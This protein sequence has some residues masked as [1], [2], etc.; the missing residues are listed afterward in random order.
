MAPDDVARPITVMQLL[1]ALESGGVERSTIE[2]AQA[3]AGAG[4]RALVVSAGGRLVAD[5]EAVGGHHLELEIGRKSLFTLRHVFTLRRL[6]EQYRPDIVHARSRL[7]A[8]IGWLA[9]RGLRGPRPAFVTTVHGLNSVSGYSAILTRGERVICVS[10][11]VRSHVLAHYP[12]VDPARLRVIER[13]VDAEDFP[14]GH[15]ADAAWRAAF[16]AAHPALSE[17]S[18]FVLPGRGTRLKGHEQAIDFITRLRAAGHDV[19]LLLQGVVESGRERYLAQLR[20]HAAQRG[21]AGAVVLAPPRRDI[22]EV[23]A[24]AFAVLQLSTK[25]EA[26]GRTV[27]EALALG[28]PV[29]GWDRG[30]VGELLA[31]SFPEGAVA[32]DDMDALVGRAADWLASPP[33]PAPVHPFTLDAMQAATLAVYRE[34]A[35]AR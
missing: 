23:M 5:L 10:G 31:R 11:T 20:A 34:V 8:W 24:E 15:R 22:R 27:V 35:D 21:V 19:A 7:P 17:R 12:K 13:G 33:Q 18:W 3:L 32:P 6:L 28:R 26:F 25:P 1:P 29:L 30:G 4:D 2:I 14:R 16:L 9:L